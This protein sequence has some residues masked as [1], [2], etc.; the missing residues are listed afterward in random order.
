MKLRWLCV[1]IGA[2]SPTVGLAQQPPSSGQPPSQP[3]SLDQRCPIPFT[4]GRT[5]LNAEA[6]ARVTSQ[7]ADNL[8]TGAVTSPTLTA[9]YTNVRRIIAGEAVQALQTLR[10]SYFCRLR[11]SLPP[12]KL[13]HLQL[14]EKELIR[15]TAVVFLQS[16]F[17][18]AST[19][20]ALYD[21]LEARADT[22]LVGWADIA[23]ANRVTRDEV[24]A[25]IGTPNFTS[26]SE[27]RV[28]LE[29]AIGQVAAGACLG[30]LHASLAAVDSATLVTLSN[31]RQAMGDL[32]DEPARFAA[33]STLATGA[34][35]TFQPGTTAQVTAQ[36][37]GANP[38]ARGQI[39]SCMRTA[40]ATIIQNVT[41]TVPVNNSKPQSQSSAVQPTAI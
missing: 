3:P 17:T 31:L 7:I 2:I 33:Y 34:Q 16:N 40:S 1:L 15:Q 36:I 24:Y 4:V 29:L 12:A 25:A 37:A 5:A 26:Q 23:L 10:N 35:A 13:P 21:Q 20:G 28:G 6:Y 19:V 41:Q 39:Q 9:F 8:P 11:A 14:M 22:P 27:E 32:V 30:T 18:D 38:A